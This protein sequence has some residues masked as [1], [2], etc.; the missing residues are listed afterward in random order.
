MKMKTIFQMMFHLRMNFLSSKL[1]LMVE[2]L[3]LFEFEYY[4]FNQV[5]PKHQEDYRLAK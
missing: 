2:V 1:I 3:T 4:A 5:I